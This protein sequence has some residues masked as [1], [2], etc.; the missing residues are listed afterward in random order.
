LVR[1]LGDGLQDDLA[2]GACGGD[3][4]L[5]DVP[6]AQYLRE[7]VGGGVQVTEIA[8][9]QRAGASDDCACRLRNHAVSARHSAA[10]ASMLDCQRSAT[11]G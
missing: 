1:E 3:V 6:E 4:D 10:A 8:V 7:G 11:R 2:T 9:Y 5:N